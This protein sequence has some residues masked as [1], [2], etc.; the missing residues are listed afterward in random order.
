MTHATSSPELTHGEPHPAV[1]LAEVVCGLLAAITGTL[2]FWRFL[3]GGRALR[4][5][6]EKLSNDF[7]ALMHRLATAPPP[8]PHIAAPVT[9]R[10]A[11]GKRAGDVRPHRAIGARPARRTIVARPARDI[12]KPAPRPPA[13]RPRVAARP[14]T[15]PTGIA[16]RDRR[17]QKPHPRTWENRVHI[18]S[19]S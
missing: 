8:V 13:A 14:T 17:S 18:I 1:R 15:S 10:R 11:R 4:A 5:S 6:L 9:P 12:P 7:A 19:I 16:M 2:G 3:P